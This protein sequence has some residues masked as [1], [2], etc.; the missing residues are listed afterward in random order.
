MNKKNKYIFLVILF[1]NI[2]NLQ[3]Q[4]SCVPKIGDSF[5]PISVGVNFRE[6]S[7]LKSKIIYKTAD[8]EGEYFACIEDGD[9][10]DFVKL[11]IGFTP[12]FLEKNGLKKKLHKTV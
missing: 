11:Q 7:N 2:I 1:F 6:N 5:H 8:T 4:I 10:N 9:T 3:S 12:D